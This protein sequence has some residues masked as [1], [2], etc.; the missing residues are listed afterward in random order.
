MTYLL[1]RPNDVLVH[2][3]LQLNKSLYLAVST[4]PSGRHAFNQLQNLSRLLVAQ[5][6]YH[7]VRHYGVDVRS[8]FVL[9]IRRT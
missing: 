3:W 6:W 2:Y 8:F 5:Q 4:I 1:L 9:T 7:L